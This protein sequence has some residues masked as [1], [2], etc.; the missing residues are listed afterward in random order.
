MLLAFSRIHLRPEI[1]RGFST[2]STK[3]GSVVVDEVEDVPMVV[4]LKDSEVAS[5]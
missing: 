5:P 1:H 3:I 2:V 4:E